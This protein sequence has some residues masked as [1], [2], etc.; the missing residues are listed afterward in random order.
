MNMKMN[1]NTLISQYRK[2]LLGLWVLSMSF[3]LAQQNLISWEVA[4]PQLNRKFIEM[5]LNKLIEND[6]FEQNSIQASDVIMVQMQQQGEKLTLKRLRAKNYD[7][8]EYRRF[9]MD[10]VQKLGP[11]I[12]NTIM[13]RKYKWAEIN[14]RDLSA[15]ETYSNIDNILNERSFKRARDGFWWT[16]SQV[17]VSTNQSVYI[18]S[19]STNQAFRLETGISDLGLHRQFFGNT[20]LGLSNDISST[21]FIVPRTLKANEKIQQPLDGTFGI[22]FKFDTHSIGGQVNYM[23]SGNKFKTGRVFNEEHVVLPSASGLVYWS[24]TFAINNFVDLSKVGFLKRLNKNLSG[25]ERTDEA[26]GSLRLKVGLSFTEFI[27]AKLKPGTKDTKEGRDLEITDRLNKVDEALGF[28]VRSELVTDNKKIKAFAQANQ[29]FN[30][31][32]SLAFGAEYSIKVL[33]LGFE[34]VNIPKGSG[35]EFLE[36]NSSDNLWKWYPAGEGGGQVVS[37]YISFHF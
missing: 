13:D 20:I 32:S 29:S 4:D 24:N 27:H 36:S 18:R 25:A 14:R 34:V 35:L 7:S 10:Q 21:Y 30:G 26:F 23:D 19:K 8:G 15:L 16:T 5:Y 3:V 33:K 17:E 12:M 1:S 6:K 22:G 37:P 28:F 2:F 9:M 11:E 31:F